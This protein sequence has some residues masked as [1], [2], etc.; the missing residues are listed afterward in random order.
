MPLRKNSTSVLS[1]NASPSLLCIRGTCFITDG[2]G[3]G[4]GASVSGAD[5][6]GTPLR[7]INISK[8]RRHSSTV[9]AFV[10]SRCISF[11][12]VWVKKGVAGGS[13]TGTALREIVRTGESGCCG[14]ELA[15]F[16]GYPFLAWPFTGLGKRR[17][18]GFSCVSLFDGI[19]A[20]GTVVG[21]V[22]TA[23][24][25]TGVSRGDGMS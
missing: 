23:F 6:L 17:W 20:G 8:I 2:D 22:I 7:A 21:F 16:G 11:A 15:S 25:I 9:V 5:A 24:S 19:D 1:S 12:S 3:E 4:Y 14:S 13:I 18:I 10:K